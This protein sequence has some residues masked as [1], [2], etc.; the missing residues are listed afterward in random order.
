MSDNENR[1]IIH[2]TGLDEDS[3]DINLSGFI[4]QLELF[5]TAV[6]ETHAIARDESKF[7]SI[8][9]VELHKNSPGQVVVDVEKK[10]GGIVV[11]AS[12]TVENF[13]NGLNLISNG[14]SPAD[15]R[16]STLD[17]FRKLISLQEKKVI[18]KLEFSRNGEPRIDVSNMAKNVESILG[19]E[20]FE[21][22]SMT[23]M[24]DALNFH[25][26]NIFYVY[27]TY[28]FPR[29]KCIVTKELVPLVVQAVKKYVTVY[30]KLHFHTKFHEDFPE[31]IDVEE[32]YVHPDESSLP[33]L[34]DLQ[35]TIK[36]DTGGLDSVDFVRKIRDE[37]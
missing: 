33:S 26:Q 3:G 27:P 35:S 16:Y 18:K 24:L 1:I 17:A 13:F 19:P 29:I 23:G 30:G 14:I 22:G 37:W 12:E 28:F 10:V 9:V 15:F 20:V 36:F 2:I 34:A 21:V 11:P 6:D 31:K 7:V 32:I 25:Q 4:K 5:K 8:K